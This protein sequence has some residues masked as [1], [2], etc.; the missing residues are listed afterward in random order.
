[1]A[2]PAAAQGLQSGWDSVLAGWDSVL[3]GFRLSCPAVRGILV[4]GPGIEPVSP[5]DRFLTTGPPGT[6]LK[7]ILTMTLLRHVLHIIK[8]TYFQCMIQ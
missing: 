6:S 2:S 8:Y 4:P 1:M 3:A 7:Q 5:A